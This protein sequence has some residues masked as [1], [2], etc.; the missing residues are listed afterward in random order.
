MVE[1]Q[2][3]KPL[4]GTQILRLFSGWFILDVDTCWLL[5]PDVAHYTH[6]DQLVRMDQLIADNAWWLAIPLAFQLF[7]VSWF[8]LNSCLG[9]D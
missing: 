2:G 6:T 5:L 8:P 3:I 9:F 7:R 4:R 1:C